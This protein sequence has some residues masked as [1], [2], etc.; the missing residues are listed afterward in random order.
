MA[1]IPLPSNP[2]HCYVWTEAEKVVIR[3]YAAAVSAADNAALQTTLADSRAYVERLTQ[4]VGEVL[5]DNAALREEVA[6]MKKSWGMLAD[7]TIEFCEHLK[8][9]MNPSDAA[10]V[11]KLREIF[12][13]GL[14]GADK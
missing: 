3:E 2:E 6:A 5:A 1:D 13:A 7:A 11:D 12:D 9:E 8:P 10:M 4:R 14:K